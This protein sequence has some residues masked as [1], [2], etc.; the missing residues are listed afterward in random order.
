M[1]CIRLTLLWLHRT[2]SCNCLAHLNWTSY[3]CKIWHKRCHHAGAS[4]L[5]WSFLPVCLSEALAQPDN[6]ESTSIHVLLFKDCLSLFSLP[7]TSLG[8]CFVSESRSISDLHSLYV[9]TEDVDTLKHAHTRAPI[10]AR[11]H[12]LGGRSRL[13]KRQCSKEWCRM[14]HC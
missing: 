8:T 13:W 5:V 6:V 9:H 4:C 12:K 7:V 3:G 2:M 11:T 10:C 1:F 14:S